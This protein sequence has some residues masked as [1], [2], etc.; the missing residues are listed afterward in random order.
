MATAAASAVPSQDIHVCEITDE[1]QPI[2]T[3]RRWRG[4]CA[5]R[6]DPSLIAGDDAGS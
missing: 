1:L 4:R 3:R 6:Y 5:R 2:G